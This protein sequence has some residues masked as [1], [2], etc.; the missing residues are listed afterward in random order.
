MENEGCIVITKI[1]LEMSPCQVTSMCLRTKGS[2]RNCVRKESLRRT[3]AETRW[4]G[5][6][7]FS[8]CDLLCMSLVGVSSPSVHRGRGVCGEEQLYGIKVILSAGEVCNYRTAKSLRRGL[9]H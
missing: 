8:T 2:H 1:I 9:C 7:S 4:A 6:L 5:S 3:G